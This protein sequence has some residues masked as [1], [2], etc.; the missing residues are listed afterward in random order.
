ME[1]RAHRQDDSMHALP[2]RT[3]QHIAEAMKG[4]DRTQIVVIGSKSGK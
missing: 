2:D 1:R 3:S 4:A